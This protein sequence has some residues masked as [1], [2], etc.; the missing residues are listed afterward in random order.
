MRLRFRN[1]CDSEKLLN[2][3]EESYGTT[4][5]TTS[6]KKELYRRDHQ[7]AESFQDY[8]LALVRIVDRITHKDNQDATELK[9]RLIYAM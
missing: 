5:S 8:S 1:D 9:E 6:L 7:E 2:A 4:D 3:I